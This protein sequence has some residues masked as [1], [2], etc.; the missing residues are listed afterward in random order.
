MNIVKPSFASSA[1]SLTQLLI[2]KPN[3]MKKTLFTTSSFVLLACLFLTGCQQEEVVTPG[4]SI[5][6][7]SHDCSLVCIDPDAPVY[8]EHTDF[9]LESAG[10]NFRRFDYTVYNTLS[11]FVVSWQ[12]SASQNTPRR[13]TFTVSGGGF[14]APVSFTTTCG[15]APQSGTTTL[16][17]TAPWAAC[18]DVNFTARLE[19]CDGLLKASK[20]GNYDL[21]GACSTCDDEAFSYSTTDNLNIVFT[22]NAASELTDAVVEFTFPQVLNAELN[23]DGLYTG[24]DGKLYT[25]NNAN[26]QTVFTWTGDIGCTSATGSTFAFSHQAD[27]SAPPANDGQA[28]IWTDT[29]VNGLSVKGTNTNIVYQGCN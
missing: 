26:N 19:D 2:A 8:H 11:G 24:A 15:Q 5:G 17:F 3:S 16:N 18:D 9:V 4:N 29:K 13:L 6:A 21:V 10:P 1:N 27:C 20:V 25:V 28:V 14:S 22:Y 7:R 23:E 12:Y